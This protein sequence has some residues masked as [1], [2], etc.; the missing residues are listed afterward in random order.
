MQALFPFFLPLQSPATCV[1]PFASL[2]TESPSSFG[3]RRDDDR[4]ADRWKTP[5]A[6]EGASESKRIS[7]AEPKKDGSALPPLRPGARRVPGAPLTLGDLVHPE[8]HTHPQP[9]VHVSP[10]LPWA[11]HPLST[12]QATCWACTV[13]ILR[14]SLLV[15]LD[16]SAGERLQGLSPWLVLSCSAVLRH[17][18]RPSLE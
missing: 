3:K 14:T 18:P 8:C 13:L 7:P 17:G 6:S 12:Q 10:G 9:W 1:P 15:E 4:R 5:P 2:R 11:A 16:P